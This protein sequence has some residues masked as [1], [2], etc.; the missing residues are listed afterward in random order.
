MPT[1]RTKS[2]FAILPDESRKH[3]VKEAQPTWLPPMLATLTDRRFSDPGWLFERKIDGYRCVTYRHGSS[4][5]LMSR[6]RNVLNEDYPEVVAALEAQRP[7]DYIIDGEVTAFEGKASSFSALQRR[8][9]LR[10]TRLRRPAKFRIVY[11]VFDLLYL[12]GY[13]T[14]RLPLTDRIALLEHLFEWNEVLQRSVALPEEGRQYYARACKSGWEG[15]IAKRADAP[16]VSARSNDWL[17]FKCTNR[18]EFVIG[19]FTAPQGAREEFGALLVG[20]YEGTKLIYAGK[21]GTGFSAALLRSL[22]RSLHEL[23]VGKSPFVGG[24]DLP[25]D[26]HWVKPRLV[27]EIAFTEW[28]PEGKLRHPAFQGLREDKPAS[29]VIRERPKP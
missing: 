8:D 13:L 12:D 6:N 11:V 7:T 1:T 25:K 4:L 21:V 10:G 3:L 2:A 27:G 17:K 18:Q 14:T 5:R 26:A 9:L 20:Y 28:T 29:K 19:G 16:Y 15:L 24:A 22:G 23:Q